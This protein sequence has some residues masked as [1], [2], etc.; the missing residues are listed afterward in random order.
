MMCFPDQKLSRRLVGSKLKAKP[1]A[2]RRSRIAQEKSIYRLRFVCVGLR[3][4]FLLLI[5]TNLEMILKRKI[6][7]KT[8]HPGTVL[9]FYVPDGGADGFVVPD[10]VADADIGF[11]VCQQV[12]TEAA[13]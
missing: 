1:K 2:F 7:P 8:D 6:D 13:G 12:V 10:N 5:A 3:Q 4:N 11:K 9:G